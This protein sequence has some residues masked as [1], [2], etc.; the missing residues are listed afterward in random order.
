MDEARLQAKNLLDQAKRHGE[1][2]KSLTWIIPLII[3]F[4]SVLVII[5]SL[6]A[7]L[8]D[9][10]DYVV[11]TL[12]VPTTI[13]VWASIGSLSSMIFRYYR[14]E[15]SVV[16]IAEIR[17]NIGR[18]WFGVISGIFFY[19]VIRS[20]LFII[21]NQDIDVNSVSQAHQQF[22]W[23]LVWLVSFSDAIFERVIAR[24]TGNVLGDDAPNA[25][26]DILKVVATEI[27][28]VLDKTYN[29]YEDKLLELTSRDVS[30]KE[31]SPPV[32]DKRLSEKN[33]S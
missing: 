33:M 19:L 3:I 27:N 12:G 11:P 6:Y 22:I 23:A 14:R 9:S 29:V 5:F 4:Y 13:I 2:E 16:M 8:Q 30:S 21:S 17:R 1:Y 20:G 32:P 15:K 31:T 25:I 26:D 10:D 7:N 28:D 24:V 18:F